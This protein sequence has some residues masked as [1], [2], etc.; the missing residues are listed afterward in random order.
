M[1]RLQNTLEMGKRMFED[2]EKI[3]FI[4]T[5]TS[6]EEVKAGEIIFDELKKAGM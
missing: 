3:N 6:P 1:D 5:S 2:L 4:R